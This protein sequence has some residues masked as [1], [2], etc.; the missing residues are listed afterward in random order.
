MFSLFFVSHRLGIWFNS[1]HKL[2]SNGSSMG[3]LG[4]A[5][6]GGHISDANES[7]VS[8]YA[9]AIGY[10]SCVAIELWALKDGINLCISLKH[11]AVVIELDAK[12]VVD[13]LSKTTRSSNTI[14]II[15]ADYKEGLKKTPM[16]TMQH[17]YR[18]AN[19]CA[20]ALARRE[21]LLPQDFVIFQ[22]PPIEVSFLLSLD[23][24]DVLYDRFVSFFEPF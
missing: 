1:L 16:T 13:L 24:T 20:E 21:A 23:S 22:E 6:G 11:H 9:R 15:A 17:C 18:E 7:W 5:K 3:N 4:S 12:L 19:K 10:T 8:G 14:D 2:N